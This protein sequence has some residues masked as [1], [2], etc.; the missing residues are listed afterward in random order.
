MKTLLILNAGIEAVPGI[1]KAKSMGLRIVL[2]DKNKLS[3]GF[4]YADHKVYASIY[5]DKK[6]I[7]SL[8]KIFR[9]IKID[10][11][12]TFSSDATLSVAKIANKYD[13]PGNT[14]QSAILSTDKIKMKKKLKKNKI[15]TPWFK[16]IKNLKDLQS[17]IKANKSKYIIKPIDNRGARGVLQID[18]QTDLKWAYNYCISRSI[19]KK[20]I[21][22]KFLKGK[23]I[24]TESILYNKDSI[25]PGM[26]ERNYEYLKKFSPF[27]IENGGQQ[28]INL[29]KD[30]IKNISDLVVRAGRCLGVKKGIVKGDVVLHKNKP[31]VIEIAT[32]LSGGWMSSHQIPIATGVDI[33]KI[34]IK[35]SL[36]EKINLSYVKIKQK[37]A[38]AIRYL[39]PSENSFFKKK[40][41]RIS[42][43]KYVVKFLIYLKN[44]HIVKKFTDHTTR[45]GFVITAA[46]NKKKAILEAKKFIKK[47]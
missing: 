6:I 46:Q 20:I 28:P 11:V 41:K 10:G 44:N 38:T 2:C 33:L 9:K 23:Q 22:E 17:V 5:N 35:L 7:Q 39:F 45:A 8:D 1:I 29:S 18:R 30:K 19:K 25:T 27:V 34:A 16:E 26:I 36:G 40:T 21:I 13:L 4:K 15:S 37:K 43:N 47:I 3:P 14:I 12:I 42:K 32:R 31:Y 24:S